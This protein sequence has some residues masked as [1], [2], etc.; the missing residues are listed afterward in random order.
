M[1][2]P[3]VNVVLID[4]KTSKANEMVSP[5]EDGSYTILINSRLSNEGQL[6]AYKHALEHIRNQDFEKDNVQEVEYA[7]H[8]G[9]EKKEIVPIPAKIYLDR[10]TRLKKERKRLQ[11]QIEQDQERVNF[12]MQHCDMFARAEHYHLYGDEL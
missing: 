2:T 11:K 4:F 3:D 8:K 7:A 10:I 6:R 1:T 12:I 9:I 5:N